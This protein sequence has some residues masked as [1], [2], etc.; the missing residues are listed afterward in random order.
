MEQFDEN[1]PIQILEPL[2]V[3]YV[4]RTL[5]EALSANHK[6]MGVEKMWKRTKGK[7]VKVAVLDTGVPDHPD[8]KVAG[9][10]SFIRGY[11]HDLNGHGSHVAGTI[12]AIEGNGIGIAGIAPEVD[13]YCGAVMGADGAGSLRDI[14]DGIYWAVDE[15]GADI[16]NMSLGIAAVDFE[17]SILR[18]AC[19]YA[20]SKG[21]TIFAAAGNEAGAVGQPARYPTTISVGAISKNLKHANFSNTGA[22]VDFVSVGVDVYSTWLNQSYCCLDGTSMACPAVAGFGALLVADARLRGEELKPEDLK[23]RLVSM[24]RDIGEPG[25]DVVFGF[26]I[27]DANRIA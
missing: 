23:E 10:K 27:P 8:I 22:T 9:G 20:W 19:D 12:A 24:S 13:L 11:Y 2:R 15:V 6:L 21:S 26:G 1:Q 14:A 4:F 7:G 18:R 16:I 5:S 3:K 25:R 17:F